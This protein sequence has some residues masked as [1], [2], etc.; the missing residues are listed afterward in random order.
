MF[1]GKKVSVVFATYRE[2][3]SVRAAIEDFFSTGLVDELIVVNNNAEEG[4]DEEVKKTK[5]K[6]IYQPLQGY[7]FAF[8][9]GIAEAIGDYIILCE[10][11]STYSAKDAEKFLAYGKDFDAVFGTRTNTS[12]IAP[13]S[14][15]RPLRRLGNVIYGKIIQ[16]LYGTTSLT[17]IGCTYKLFRKE[18]LRKIEPFFSTTNPLFATELLLLSSLHGLK[19]V[20]IPVHYGNRSGQSTIISGWT[21]L[22]K[23]AYKLLVFIIGYRIA[24]MFGKHR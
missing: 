20:E 10:P 13:D 2:K 18:A 21:K 17:E 22:V 16:T 24:A 9:K 11:D 15:M 14:D 12:T 3:N 8:R 7:G 1:N 19:F 23:W 6:L 5:A 4:T